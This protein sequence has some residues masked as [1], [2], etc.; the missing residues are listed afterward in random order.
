MNDE[1]FDKQ[2]EDN[3]RAALRGDG[4]AI[5]RKWRQLRRAV[6]TGAKLRLPMMKPVRE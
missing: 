5:A 6:E 1:D 3:Y 4:A 2:Y